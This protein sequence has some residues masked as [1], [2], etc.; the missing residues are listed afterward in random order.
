LSRQLLTES[1]VLSLAGG[2]IAFVFAFWGTRQLTRL[3]GPHLPRADEVGLDW[4][5][6]L[7]LLA[8]CLVA[9]VLVGLAPALMATRADPHVALHDA[10]S[11]ATM[12]VAPRRLRDPLVVAEVALACAL[13]VGATLLMRELVRLRHTD[14][15]MVTSHVVTF[16]LGQRMVAG[17]DGREFYE[18]A[19]RVSALAG[20]TS[21]G[22]TQLLPLQSW[23]WTSNSNDFRV[24]GQ[25]P[26]SPVFLIGLRY[27][28]PDYFRTL[29]IPIRRGRAFTTR[30]TRDAPPVILINET[31]ARRYFGDA[32]P[33]GAPTTRGTIV[34]VVGDI[35]QVSFDK[36]SEPELYYPIAQN[37]SQVSDLGM[38]LIVRTEG[39]PET[40]IDAVRGVVRQA[41]PNQAI[42]NVKT[43]A[44]VVA[45]SL[46]EFT[47]FLALIASFAGLALLLAITG[48]YGVIAYVSTSRTREF[49][50]RM[51]LGA[52]RKRVTRLVLGQG[53]RLTMFGLALGVAGSVL[54]APALMDLPVT[55]RPLDVGTLAP[56]AV[57]IG[58]VAL[59]A[60]LI[61]ARRAAAVDPMS[62]LRSE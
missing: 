60:C 23:G 55:I 40:L 16:H 7:F 28:T 59:I 45:D 35:R 50:I 4:R 53:L 58:I 47:L 5:V 33:T 34:G 18:I 2:A 10:G 6:F 42:F 37:W 36:P 14:P 3:A 17:S 38:S 29:G 32:D 21:A 48:T 57:A 49:A 19:D 1:L 43:M 41:N 26:L 12:G 15:G 52:D 20:V 51:A 31:L 30:D 61:P 39:R 9:A 22:F 24:R 13:G 27:V 8:A 46:S 62:A 54:A 11:R 56:V 44:Q 25:P